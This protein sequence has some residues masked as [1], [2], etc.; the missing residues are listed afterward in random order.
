MIASRRKG[1]LHR[2]LQVARWIFSDGS[3]EQRDAIAK[4]T[5]DGLRYLIEELRYDRNQNEDA[6]VD[7]PLLRWGC[8]HL[9]LAMSVSGYETDR[10]VIC[11]AQAVQDDP[12]PEVR[13]AQRPVL[14]SVHAGTESA[15]IGEV[16]PD[17]MP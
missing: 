7:V 12:L 13:H 16:L 11:W 5:L 15:G 10:A 4:L 6:E 2:A 17:S 1:V 9:A 8:A 3:P 14:A